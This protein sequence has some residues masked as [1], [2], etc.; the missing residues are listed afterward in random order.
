MTRRKSHMAEGTRVVWPRGACA[1]YDISS[2][3][4][5]RWE[6]RGRMPARDVHVGGKSGWRP[7]TLD[8]YEGGG[9]TR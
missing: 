3:T 6:R 5:W 2:V 8:L 7:E 9:R 1:R 4:L